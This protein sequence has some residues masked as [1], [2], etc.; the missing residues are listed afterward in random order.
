ML[1]HETGVLSATTAFGKN[2]VAARLIARRGVNTLVLAHRRQLLEQWVERLSALADGAD[3]RGI[4]GVA[5]IRRRR[6]CDCR[7]RTIHWEGFDDPRLG[8][9][10]LALPVS[11]RGTVAQY[12]GR[13][14]RLQE[15]KAKR[16]RGGMTARHFPIGK[17]GG[18]LNINRL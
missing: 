17:Q 13:L 5:I 15:G 12:V 16:R 7:D 4:A 11:W 10:F 3:V 8:T 1:R 2:V 6:Q 9:L 14:H 18:R